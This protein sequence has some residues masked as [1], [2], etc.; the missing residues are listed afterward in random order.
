[1]PAYHTFDLRVGAKS[2]Q[3]RFSLYVQNLTDEF[4]ITAAD[5]R[6]TVITSP[7]AKIYAMSLIRPRTVGISVAR[8]F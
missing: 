3:W 6:S 4:G 7:Y 5:P 8:T 2:G 1:M